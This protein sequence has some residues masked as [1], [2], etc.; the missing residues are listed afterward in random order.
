MSTDPESRHH[1]DRCAEKVLKAWAGTQTTNSLWE[2]KQNP[3]VVYR[4]RSTKLGA[5]VQKD[6]HQTLF[7]AQGRKPC[8][9]WRLH[10]KLGKKPRGT[11]ALKLS[12]CY[13]YLDWFCIYLKV[14]GQ[15]SDMII[16]ILS[17]FTKLFLESHSNDSN[18]M[19]KEMNIT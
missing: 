6:K 11:Q 4:P 16:C 7:G 17:L 10:R 2:S 14:S 1:Q 13:T 5:E 3:G 8:T 9:E 19:R 18:C 12:E 15:N